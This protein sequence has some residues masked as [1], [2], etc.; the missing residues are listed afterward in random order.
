MEFPALDAAEELSC[1]VLVIGGG[2]AGTMAALTAAEHDSSLLLSKR[3]MSAAPS[4]I[5]GLRPQP[6]PGFRP[7]LRS[8][9]AGGAG[10]APSRTPLRKHRRR[11]KRSGRARA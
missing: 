1:E 6:P 4:R 3:R 9:I 8:A 2:T 10:I 7:G 11:W 5:R